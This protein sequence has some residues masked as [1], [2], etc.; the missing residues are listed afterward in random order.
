MHRILNGTIL[1]LRHHRNRPMTKWAPQRGIILAC[2][3]GMI[4]QL[5]GVASAILACGCILPGRTACCRSLS[6]GFATA[7]C[8]PGAVE[9]SCCSTCPDD[10]LA[11]RVRHPDKMP[12]P[13]WQALTERVAPVPSSTRHHQQPDTLFF[14]WC[15]DRLESDF[16]SQERQRGIFS[17]AAVRTQPRLQS[18]LCVWII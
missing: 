8:L 17:A 15:V 10:R 1:Q 14:V 9:P 13:C 18:L 12:C 2:C 16:F 3:L 5:P 7:C 6:D 11:T 4:I